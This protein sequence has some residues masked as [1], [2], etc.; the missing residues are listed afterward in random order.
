[1]GEVE[2]EDV[3]KV[4]RGGVEAVSSLDLDVPDGSFFVLVGPSG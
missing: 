3:T 1:M 2:L 4:Y